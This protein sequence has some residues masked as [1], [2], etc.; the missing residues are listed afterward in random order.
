VLF[1]SCG[2]VREILPDLIDIGVGALL[3]FQTTAVGMDVPSMV[4]DFGGRLAFYGGI[5]IQQLLSFGTPEEVKAT[6][7]RNVEAFSE[8][9]GYIVA[10]SHHGVTTIKGEN[11]EAMCAAARGE[12]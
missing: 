11:I 12:E 8:C 5:D 7:R 6:V 9:G 10:N 4:R 2:A 3:V 1:H